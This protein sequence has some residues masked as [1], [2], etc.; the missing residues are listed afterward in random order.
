MLIRIFGAIILLLL[1][2]VIGSFIGWL[3]L[4]IGSSIHTA[5]TVGGLTPPLLIM[6]C[7]ILGC[8]NRHRS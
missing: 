4:L 8:F 1:W 3:A 2:L 6:L 7:N 5:V